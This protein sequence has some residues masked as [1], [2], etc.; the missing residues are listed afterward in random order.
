M[1]RGHNFKD[2]ICPDSIRFKS[3]YFEMDNKVGRIL[4]LK[5]FASFLKDDMIA[6]L[7]DISRNL[8]L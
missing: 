4:F 6:K 8:M 1:K 2:F 3:D 5:D 7:T